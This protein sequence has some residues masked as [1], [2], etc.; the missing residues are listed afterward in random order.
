M[1]QEDLKQEFTPEFFE[2]FMYEPEFRAIFLSIANGESPYK[3]IEH[4]CKSK[5]ETREMLEKC[6]LSS[7]PIK[8]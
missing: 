7:S 1:K 2:E 3:I 6:V 5:K 8:I 4:L